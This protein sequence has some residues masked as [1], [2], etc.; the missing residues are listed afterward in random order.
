M[1]SGQIIECLTIPCMGILNLSPVLS[2]ESLFIEDLV[3]DGPRDEPADVVRQHLW[4]RQ[5]EHELGDVGEDLVEGALCVQLSDAL[6]C[7]C[8][9]EQGRH[10]LPMVRLLL[11]R[12][13][14]RDVDDASLPCTSRDG[15]CCSCG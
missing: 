2:E 1:H 8:L 11:E 9:C 5:V 10:E 7:D 3:G 12:E 4:S 6:L 13:R 15:G 14:H